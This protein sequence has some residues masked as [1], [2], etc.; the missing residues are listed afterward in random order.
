MSTVFA[1]AVPHQAAGE[2]DGLV[3]WCPNSMASVSQW[4]SVPLWCSFLRIISPQKHR[5][6][7][8]TRRNLSFGDY[9]PLVHR[10]LYINHA[11]KYTYARI[12]SRVPD[13]V[14]HHK[15]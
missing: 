13:S 14:A 8:E 7:F 9:F 12:Q 1:L 5:G 10:V 4:I 2:S 11:R 15:G 6:C 3:G